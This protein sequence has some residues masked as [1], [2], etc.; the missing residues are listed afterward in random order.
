MESTASFVR[1]GCAFLAASTA[2]PCLVTPKAK[3]TRVGCGN[4]KSRL[5][6][7]FQKPKSE[8]PSLLQ[9]ELRTVCRKSEWAGQWD[10][11]S[12]ELGPG[13][14]A[15]SPGQAWTLQSDFQQT[16]T[17]GGRARHLSASCILEE[18]LYNVS[19][20]KLPAWQ[21]DVVLGNQPTLPMYI[22]RTSPRPDKK[23]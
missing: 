16:S 21:L 4:R 7:F 1:S 9:E 11:A 22:A 2:M 6:L 5:G 13:G 14:R 12:R 19:S 3:G 15:Q 20:I 23:P 17:C 8:R 10:S 18:A